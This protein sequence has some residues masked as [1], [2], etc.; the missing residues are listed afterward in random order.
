MAILG[1]SFATSDFRWSLEALRTSAL[2]QGCTAFF[3]YTPEDISE[4]VRGHDDV[5]TPASR[6][7]GYWAWKG[8][9]ID[10]VLRDHAENGDVVVYIDAGILMVSTITP[11]I[12]AMQHHDA[13]LFRVGEA[14]SKGYTQRRFTKLDTFDAMGTTLDRDGDHYQLMGGLQ[15]YRKN[16]ATQA[17]VSMLREALLNPACVDDIHRQPNHVDFIDHRHDQS[18]L[19][20]LFHS[21]N[22]PIRALVS[23]CPSQFGLR[24][25]DPAGLNLQQLTQ[26]HRRRMAPLPTVTVVTATIGTDRLEHCVKSV[27]DQDLPCVTHL[28]VVDGPEHADRVNA[29]VARHKDR[30]PLRVLQLPHNVGAD[31][32]NGHRAYAAASYIAKSGFVAF[33]DEDNTFE[34]H[35]VS[36]M[37]KAM[38]T[39]RQS[40]TFS[41]RK[42]VDEDGTLVCLDQCESLGSVTPS[43]LDPR[44]WFVDANCFLMRTE[45]AVEVSPLWYSKFRDPLKGESD[46][47]ITRALLARHGPVKG[48]GQFSVAYMVGNTARSVRREFFEQGNLVRGHCFDGRPDIYLFHFNAVATRQLFE[49]QFR[50]D[51]CYAYEEWQLTQTRDLARQVNLHDGFVCLDYIPPGAIV[52]VNLCHPSQVPLNR[53]AERTDLKRVCYTLESPNIAH[54]SQWTADFLDRYFDVWLTYWEP[55]LKERPDKARYCPHNTHW[56]NLDDEIDRTAG[57]RCNQ[58]VSRTVCCVLANRPGLN[59]YVIDGREMCQLDGL[60]QHYV[61]DLNIDLYGIGWGPGLGSKAR[62]VRTNSKGED[63]EHAVDIYQKYMFAVIVENCDAEGYLS[64]KAW[65]A[66][67]AGCIPIYYGNNN[68]R[69]TIPKDM[70]IDLRSFNSSRELA[71]HIDA[72]SDNDIARFRAAIS[73]GREAVLQ[74]VSQR[75]FTSHFLEGVKDTHCAE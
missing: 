31:G 1:V 60:R 70:Y 57:L 38:I 41:F 75:S 33:L 15:M 44:D 30:V 72:L 19:T 24:D 21:K 58:A 13:F 69:V 16:L 10:R 40:W 45:V 5:F 66:F 48:S 55:L 73:A 54:A 7:F 56:L 23:K 9:V 14:V 22:C 6:G 47:N 52:L 18:V 3:A 49:T 43:V 8:I 26:I 62:V 65:N 28:L 39:N 32:W 34:P 67:S 17:F 4:E 64:E 29:V 42:I 25:D 46:R 63:V 61:K 71:R 50:S 27:Q 74:R 36:S 53:L 12:K 51:R 59:K 11:Y 35:H 37:I 20:M 68:G 2:N